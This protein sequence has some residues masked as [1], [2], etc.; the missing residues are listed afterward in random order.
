MA[1]SLRKI[2]IVNTADEGGGA[3]HVSMAVLNGFLA[4]GV[5]AWLLVGSKTRNHPRVVS[6]YKSPHFNYGPYLDPLLTAEIEERRRIDRSLGLEDFNHPYSHRI[7][8]LTGSPPDLV[9]CH[10]LHGGYFDLRALAGLSARL[11]VALTVTY[12]TDGKPNPKRAQELVAALTD[13]LAEGGGFKPAAPGETAGRLEITVEDKPATA[14]KTGFAGF[15]VSVGHVLASEPEFT[16]Q[17][18]R[19]VRDLQVQIRYTPATGAPLE[20][21]YESP[22]VTVTNNTQ[23]PTDLVPMQDRKHAEPTLIGN[24][25]N[26][27]MAEFAQNQPAAAP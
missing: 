2:V 25:L 19:T 26:M 11:P 10:N 24:D 18:R 14:K 12:A 17:G 23:D 7:D 13:S 6:F 8:R 16:P 15:A 9:L 21:S 1:P 4:L 20:R 3:E 22:L 5:D 27:F